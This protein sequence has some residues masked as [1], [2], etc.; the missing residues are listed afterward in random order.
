MMPIEFLPDQLKKKRALTLAESLVL[1]IAMAGIGVTAWMASP[2]VLRAGM[3]SADADNVDRE[4]WPKSLQQAADAIATLVRKSKGTCLIQRSVNDRREIEFLALW[5]DDEHQPNQ[6]N[7]TEVILLRYSRYLRSITAYAWEP[8]LEDI[9]KAG[10]PV[11]ESL[12]RKR[13]FADAFLR[14]PKTVGRVIAVDID[15]MRITATSSSDDSAQPILEGS[16][17]RIQLTSRSYSVDRPIGAS[18]QTD[19]RPVFDPP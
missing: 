5:M 10:D 11:I 12:L 15:A 16:P 4:N 17:G 3:S 18:I 13:R 2:F 1:V 9:E 14:L 8:T 6:I 19:L 7:Q